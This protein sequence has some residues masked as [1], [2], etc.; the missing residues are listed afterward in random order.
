M[1]IVYH[2]NN[3]VVEIDYN[4]ESKSIPQNNIA[5][6]L[7]EIA[8]DHRDSLIVWCHTKLKSNLNSKRF[9]EVFH[10]NKIMASYNP[11]ERSFLS[12]AIGYVEDSPFLKIN[13]KVSYP[14]WQMSSAVGGIHASILNV[15]KEEIKKDRNFDYF[16]LSFAKLAMPNGVF[17]Y[18]EPKLLNNLLEIIPINASNSFLLFRFVKQHYKMRWIFLLFLNLF[19]YER[20]ISIG[21]LFVSIF[22]FRR[23]LDKNLSDTIQVQSINKTVDKSTIDVIIPTIGRKQF[24]YDVLKDLS[25]QSH[26][27]KNVIIIEQNPSQDSESELDYLNME[28]WPFTIKHTFT[29]QAGACN[30]RNLALAE[31]ESEWVFLNDDDNRFDSDLIEKVLEKA[32]LYGVNCVTTSYLQ[33]KEILKFSIIHQSGIFGSGNSFLKSDFLNVVSFNKALEFGYGEDTDF[34]LQLRNLGVDIIYFPDLSILHLKAPMGGFRNKFVF[35]WEQKG[36]SPKPSPNIMYV[37]S[38][39]S[40]KQQLLGYKTVLFFKLNKLNI[41]DVSKFNTSWKLSVKWSKTLEK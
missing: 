40:T 6:T 15:L 21:S 14:T 37:K 5:E 22:Y 33:K 39:Y 8:A 1:I 17:C 9:D 3:K 18:S 25:Q 23:K 12:D 4:G 13:K 36:E 2:E 11:G 35:P 38:K 24:L 29:R 16:L 10:H 41:F 7:F 32:S 30:A 34:G 20:R 26:L 31:V 27:P 19:L 28:S